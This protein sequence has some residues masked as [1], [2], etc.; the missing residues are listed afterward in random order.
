MNM[1]NGV[2]TKD[3]DVNK[4]LTKI[5]L[6]I[7]KAVPSY[8]IEVGLAEQEEQERIAKEEGRKNDL[9]LIHFVRNIKHSVDSAL[10]ESIA[11]L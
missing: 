10:D 11:N 6:T 2:E 5:F 3:E 1:T 9:T 7:A 8:I 4:T